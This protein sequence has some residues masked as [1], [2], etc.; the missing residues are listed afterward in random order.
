MAACFDW[1][2]SC[3]RLR[4]SGGDYKI[5]DLLVVDEGETRS[6]RGRGGMALES[7]TAERYKDG[8]GL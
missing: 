4:N 3:T 7:D 6:I 8:N 2:H 5:E 1:W